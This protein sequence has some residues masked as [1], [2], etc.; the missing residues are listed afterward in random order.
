MLAFKITKSILLQLELSG[1]SI[2]NVD[3]GEALD[4]QTS[5]KCVHDLGFD[6]MNF[7]LEAKNVADNMINQQP[8]D[9]DLG[10]TMLECNRLLAPFFRNYHVKFV[11]REVHEVVCVLAHAA[12]SL[13]SFHNFND[14]PTCIQDLI[15]NE[16]S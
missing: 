13:A 10:A 5:I 12:P 4:L 9:S 3:I 14:V 15:S 7:E 6:N 8:N 1:F 2:T 16:M 11:R